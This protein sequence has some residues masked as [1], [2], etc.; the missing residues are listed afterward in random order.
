MPDS[1]DMS[2]FNQTPD[3]DSSGDWTSITNF[4]PGWYYIQ[5]PGAGTLYVDYGGGAQAAQQ[6]YVFHKNAANSPINFG[7]NKIT[8][9]VGDAIVYQLANPATDSIK[10]AYSMV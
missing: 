6:I 10:L 3:T 8:V 5:V 4:N 9:S 1:P 7:P 2:Q